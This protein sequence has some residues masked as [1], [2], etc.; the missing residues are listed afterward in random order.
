MNFVPELDYDS[1]G[2]PYCLTPDSNARLAICSSGNGG[3][4]EDLRGETDEHMDG[5]STG[6]KLSSRSRNREAEQRF[7]CPFVKRFP[8]KHEKCAKYTLSRIQDVKQHILRQH[9]GPENYCPV[10]FAVFGSSRKRDEHIRLGKCTRQEKPRKVHRFH[11]EDD[12]RKALKDCRLRGS[13]EEDRWMELW[14]MTFPGT[15]RP[16]SPYIE[17]GQTEL[18]SSLRRYC[19]PEVVAEHVRKI[20]PEPC[21]VDSLQELTSIM[22]HAIHDL[23]DSFEATS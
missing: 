9:C 16:P 6:A 22:Q 17:S 8:V 1:T 18:V 2:S 14:E 7:T 20:L 19:K 13:S 5:E 12:Q 21:R 10:C 4:P 23:L 3:L 15:E 11:L